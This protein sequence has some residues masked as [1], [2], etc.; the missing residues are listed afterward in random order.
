MQLFQNL[1][2][3]QRV[4]IDTAGR[5]FLLVDTGAASSIEVKLDLP[6]QNDELIQQARAGFRARLMTARFSRVFLLA[7]VDCQVEIIIS[8]NDVD[9]SFRDGAEVNATIVGP[10]PVPVSNDRGSPGNLLHVAGVSIADAPA[11]AVTNNAPVACGPVAAV[12][13]AADATRRALRFHNLGPDPV[14]IG[15]AGITWANRV[16][17]L[18]VGDVWIEDRAANLAWS[19]ITDAGKAASVAAQGVNA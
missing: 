8:D 4:K 5:F 16:I 1:T 11:T 15:A 6:G 3:G 10:T 7:A 12:V 2:A 18:G 14:A 13:A 17:V 19:A 9:F